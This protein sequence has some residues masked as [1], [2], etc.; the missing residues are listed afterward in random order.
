MLELL[1][2]ITYLDLY[3]HLLM[4]LLTLMSCIHLFTIASRTFFGY[5]YA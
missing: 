5:A 2:P 4:L 1:D 3:Y